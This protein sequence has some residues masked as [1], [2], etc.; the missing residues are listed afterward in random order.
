MRFIMQLRLL[1]GG[2]ANSYSWVCL[3]IS[4]L[5]FM[6][7]FKMKNRERAWLIG[8][9]ALY[10]CIGVLLTVIMNTSPTGRRRNCARCSSPPPT[11]W[12]RS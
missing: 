11:Q 9:A 5:P 8:L 6:F 1:I 12:W 3:F 7:I 2:L 4:L 10:L